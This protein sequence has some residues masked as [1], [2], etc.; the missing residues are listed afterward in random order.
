[1]RGRNCPSRK[2]FAGGSVLSKGIGN[3]GMNGSHLHATDPAN[4]PL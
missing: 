4:C 2:R 3:A 1:L